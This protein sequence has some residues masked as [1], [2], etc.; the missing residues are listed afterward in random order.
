M[1]FAFNLSGSFFLSP[2]LKR[3]RLCHEEPNRLLNEIENANGWALHDKT[4][5]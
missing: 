2:S 4:H 5:V 1:R 3:V